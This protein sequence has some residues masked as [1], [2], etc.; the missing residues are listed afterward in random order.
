MAR[1]SQETQIK[2]IM[3]LNHLVNVTIGAVLKAGFSNVMGQGRSQ[4]LRLGDAIKKIEN[5]SRQISSLQKLSFDVQKASL[6]FAEAKEKVRQLKEAMRD[7]E[8]PTKQMQVNLGRAHAAVNKAKN[9]LTAKRHELINV[10]TE[11]QKSGQ[12]INNLTLQQAKLGN[13]VSVLTNKYNILDN[14]LKKRE[15]ILAKRGALRSQIFETIAL[16]AAIAAPIKAA[17][18]F[19]SVMADVRKVV[20]FS[21]SVNGL[22][23]FGNKLKSM[24]RE[25]PISAAGLAQIAAAGGQLGIGENDLPQFVNIVAKMSTAFDLMPDEA[26]DAIAKLS[27]I[28][29]IPINDITK[30]GD[31]INYLSDNTAAKARD[32]IP[33][34]AR[35]GA[36]A[37]DFGLS[38]EQTAA[39][40]DSFIALGKQPQ[41]AATAINAMLLRLNTA[42]KQSEKFQRGLSELGIEASE[43]KSS[44]SNDAQGALLSFLETVSKVE[45]QQRAG[46]LS[47]LFGLEFADDISL[48]AG[49]VDQYKKALALLG[50]QKM[51]NSMQR[52][53]ENRADTTAN[54]LQ[55]LTN[56]VVE[57]GISIGNTLLPAL[58]VVIKPLRYF[59]EGLSELSNKFPFFSKVIFGTI[60]ALVGLKIAFLGLGFAWSFIAGGA[61]LVR[62]ALVKIGIEAALAGFRLKGFNLITLISAINIRA[63]AVTETI[64]FISNLGR[65]LIFASSKL[66]IFNSLS[67]ITSNIMKFLAVGGF[68][69]TFAGALIGLA[70]GAIPILAN[71]FKILTLSL[72]TNPIGLV[73]GSIGIAAGLLITK[74][75]NVRNFFSRLWEPVQSIWQSF[76]DWLGNFWKIISAPATMI[77]KI[78][79]LNSD[80]KI[81]A[82]ISSHEDINQKVPANDYNLKSFNEPDSTL[83]QKGNNI[84][85]R[86]INNNFNIE[87]KTIPGQ[88][89]ES[90]AN[91]VLQKIKNASKGALFDT[92]MI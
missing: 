57:F 88:D 62:I 37:K 15:A 90:I 75:S 7:A 10:R 86:I 29:S 19:E 9:A 52:E 36:Q 80:K 69:K 51:Q 39:L 54:K 53:F 23:E 78:L 66:V 92:V 59:A 40:A 34:L 81:T 47:D 72:M 71:S 91:K 13:A 24:A 1:C 43:L 8:Q 46:I 27:N 22:K 50:S 87:V 45:K 20:N 60:F 63:L 35:A 41:I 64:A 55:L 11:M 67:L 5:D 2:L 17:I 70:Y 38:A 26:G 31:A 21:D 49:S 68:I 61:A 12:S 18:R 79:G 30:L 82:S 58:N 84:D 89:V 74:W 4:T 6:R 16:G 33:V 56:D 44:I 85:R 14:S 77:G 76:A 48:I 73:L 42:D 25:L 3:S 32:I 65:S 83:Y 28:F